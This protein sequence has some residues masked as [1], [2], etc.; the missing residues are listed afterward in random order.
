MVLVTGGPA[1]A[2][3]VS[4]TACDP[5]HAAPEPVV[6]WGVQRGCGLDA[7]F[8]RDVQTELE[9]SLH[10]RFAGHVDSRLAATMGGCIG[11][12]CVDWLRQQESCGSVLST[13]TLI[14]GRV[15]EVPSANGTLSLLHVW[16]YD[17]ESGR[18]WAYDLDAGTCAHGVCGNGRFADQDVQRLRPGQRIAIAL[19]RLVQGRIDNEF[20]SCQAG[21]QRAGTN[22]REQPELRCAAA[23]NGGGKLASGAPYGSGAEK[24]SAAPVAKTALAIGFGLS[25]ST[26]IVLGALAG[27]SFG[28][29]AGCDRPEPLMP[30][31]DDATQLCTP[32]RTAAATGL[33][34]AAG[35]TAVLGIGLAGSVAYDALRRSPATAS[36]SPQSVIP[37]CPWL[38]P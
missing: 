2:Q 12:T 27:S 14:G 28:D 36:R 6:L 32:F 10:R 38:L 5:F 15:D 29:K 3:P 31:V 19:G 16:R 30:P 25:A 23:L 9:V 7:G 4:A 22:C 1:L 33:G 35:A 8:A 17:L 13:G 26:L 34:V 21:C 18:T 11:A 37:S 24:S 20:L